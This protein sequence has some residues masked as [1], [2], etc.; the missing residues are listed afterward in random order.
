MKAVLIDDDVLIHIGWRM[1]AKKANIDLVCY[2]SVDEFLLEYKF[3]PFDT[4]IYIDSDL[5]NGY[6]GQI[7]SKKIYDVG[8]ES[9][10]LATG[11]SEVNIE[12][13]PWISKVIGK[14]PPF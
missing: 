6:Y 5:Q 9:I 11:Y 8:F 14:R 3:F 7:E 2:R 1:V 10:I 4:T 13:Y 12:L